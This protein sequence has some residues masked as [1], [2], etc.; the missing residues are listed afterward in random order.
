MARD[1]GTPTRVSPPCWQRQ[2]ACCTASFVAAI[3]IEKSDP[4]QTSTAGYV[5]MTQ[6]RTDHGQGDGTAGLQRSEIPFSVEPDKWPINT[7]TT[8]ESLKGVFGEWVW[9]NSDISDS[10]V[11]FYSQQLGQKELTPRLTL[12][13]LY[14]VLCFSQ[15]ILVLG[16]NQR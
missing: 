15:T 3:D 10:E 12:P 9:M 13:S 5:F 6:E 2:N 1:V 16:P 14:W 8:E 7:T 4:S 11:H